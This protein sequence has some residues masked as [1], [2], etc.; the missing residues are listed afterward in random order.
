MIH[1]CL[2]TLMRSPCRPG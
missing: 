2:C 1:D